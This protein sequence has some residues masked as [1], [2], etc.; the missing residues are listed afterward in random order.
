LSQSLI[1]L[2]FFRRYPARQNSIDFHVKSPKL[3]SGHQFKIVGF[4]VHIP[5]NC[6]AARSRLAGA[7]CEVCRSGQFLLLC[8]R[9]GC[10]D[11][12]DFESN[13]WQWRDGTWGH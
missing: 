4:H 7:S 13:R 2:F 11:D 3:V 10:A 1:K 12:R 8:G 6:P 9:N 5:K